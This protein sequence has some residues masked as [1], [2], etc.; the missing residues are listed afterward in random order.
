MSDYKYPSTRLAR[1]E[2]VED[3]GALPDFM[4]GRTAGTTTTPTTEQSSDDTPN[5]VRGL[6]RK[7]PKPEPAEDAPAGPTPASKS[8]SI[9]GDAP[10]RARRKDPEDLHQASSA[11]LPISLVE[12]LNKYR[13]VNAMSAGDII[14]AAI[15]HSMDELPTLLAGEKPAV[16]HRKPGFSSRPAKAAPPQELSK[17]LAFRLT[18]KDFAYLDELVEDLGARNRT[19]LIC[20][21]LTHFLKD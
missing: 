5:P 6:A 15:E 20:E 7:K 14:V 16:E 11:N 19:H 1:P 2:D 3:L 17:L 13:A 4:K 9:E 12:S 18:V 21:A 10:V 8:D